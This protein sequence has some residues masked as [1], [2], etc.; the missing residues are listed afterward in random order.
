MI[1]TVKKFTPSFVLYILWFIWFMLPVVMSLFSAFYLMILTLTFSVNSNNPDFYR[2]FFI[3]L[4]FLILM[5]LKFI[6]G[7]FQITVNR[8][9]KIKK[10]LILALAQF[11][12][13]ILLLI[14][15]L[16][17]GLE[18]ITG[19]SSFFILPLILEIAILISLGTY[20]ITLGSKKPKPSS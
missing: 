13:S 15:P 5:L 14:S 1:K 11:G 17:D 12:F 10:E 7:I 4:A 19:T 9:G 8:K 6:T 16:L 18:E 20:L 3:T 2:S